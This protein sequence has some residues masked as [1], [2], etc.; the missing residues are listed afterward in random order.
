MQKKQRLKVIEIAKGAASV[1]VTRGEKPMMVVTN[2]EMTLDIYNPRTGE[3]IQNIS[4][5]G[6]V[7]PLVIHKAY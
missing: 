5:F 4:D 2:G 6:N 1:A 7:T 3:L